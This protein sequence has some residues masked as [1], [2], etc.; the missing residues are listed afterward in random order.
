MHRWKTSSGLKSRIFITTHIAVI[1]LCAF[2]C[3]TFQTKPEWLLKTPV[4][5]DDTV[6]VVGGPSLTLEQAKNNAIGEISRTIL[7]QV[8]AFSSH[9]AFVATDDVQR[10]VEEELV[11]W[12]KYGTLTLLS[13]VLIRERYLDSRKQEW[14]VLAEI[15][16]HELTT[17][18]QRTMEQWSMLVKDVAAYADRT[19]IL[20]A[21]YKNRIDGTSDAVLADDILLLGKAYKHLHLGGF[22]GMAIPGAE[23]YSVLVE[24]YIELE[25]A[26]ILGGIHV[27]VEPSP[28][29]VEKGTCNSFSITVDSPAYTRIG[30]LNWLLTLDGKTLN[31]TCTT[32]GSNPAQVKIFES[33]LYKDRDVHEIMISLDMEFIGLD[34]ARAQMV[35]KVPYQV[36][37]IFVVEPML[38]FDFIWQDQLSIIDPLFMNKWE[39]LVS[40]ILSQKLKTSVVTEGNHAY[41]LSITPYLQKELENAFGI[42][43]IK[44]KLIFELSSQL[45]EVL[46]QETSETH[47]VQGVSEDDSLKKLFEKLLNKAILDNKFNDLINKLSALKI[48]D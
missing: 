39:L 17:S 35:F 48:L 31:E 3:M 13:G 4:Q 37:K 24:Q 19:T 42:Y 46:W 15:D 45:G 30:N 21:P 43:F 26:K 22:G 44:G 27:N 1:W 16:K 7:Q 40:S 28:I 8:S 41:T 14:W 47:E 6:Y 34:V 18:Y 29:V 11:Q 36:Q 9:Y 32:Y 2:S 20:L 23:G 12:A 5:T 38:G 33:S 25:L 10:L